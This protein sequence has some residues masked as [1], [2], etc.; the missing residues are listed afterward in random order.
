VQEAL[1]G[2]NLS[3][4]QD[5]VFIHPLIPDLV[6]IEGSGSRDVP[7]L[8]K[9][10]VVNGKCGVAVLRGAHIFAPG[11]VGIQSGIKKGD[12]VSIFADVRNKCLV[13]FKPTMDQVTAEGSAKNKSNNNNN[14]NNNNNDNDNSNNNFLHVGNG[15]LQMA[16]WQLFSSKGVVVQQKQQKSSL[17]ASSSSSPLSSSTTTVTPVAVTVTHPRFLSPSFQGDLA[18]QLFPQNLPSALVSHVLNPQPG[19][20][21]LDMCAAPGGKTTH[22]ALLMKDIGTVVALDSAAKRVEKLQENVDRFGLRCVKVLRRDAT[23]LCPLPSREKEV[24]DGGVESFVP[25]EGDKI[26]GKESFDRILL[27]APCSSLGQRPCLFNDLN[28]IHLRSYPDYQK[29]IFRNAMYLLKRTKG[30]LVY[31]TCTINP[32]ENEGVIAWA[33]ETFPTLRLVS[34]HPFVLARPGLSGFG[35]TEEQCRLVQRFDPTDSLDTI[36]FFVAKFESND[37]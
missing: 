10:I 4:L 20:K 9:I 6:V 32:E 24:L 28:V 2:Q 14:N 30:I 3:E 12:I 11:V 31:S 34:Q 22:V 7:L 8:D 17:S 25:K 13:G 35:L 18:Q 36:G 16:R 21:I 37:L 23:K 1:R 19:E 27:D 15:V 5:R 26:F 33:L 29:M